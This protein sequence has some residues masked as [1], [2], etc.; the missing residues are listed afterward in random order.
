MG[1]NYGEHNVKNVKSW[2]RTF[3]KEQITSRRFYFLAS[4]VGFMWDLKQFST[5]LVHCSV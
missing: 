1:H 4:R 5:E 2:K 3:E